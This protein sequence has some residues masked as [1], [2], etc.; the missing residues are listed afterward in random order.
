MLWVVCMYGTWATGA[1]LRST[2][3]ARCRFPRCAMKG[4][5]CTGILVSAWLYCAGTL[6]AVGSAILLYPAGG[7]L[8][9]RPAGFAVSLRLF[10]FLC[11][12]ALSARGVLDREEF[13]VRS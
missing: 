8:G 12:S 5:Y 1:F 4:K 13:G 7:Q 2:V 10:V 3:V 11:R 6:S 9:S